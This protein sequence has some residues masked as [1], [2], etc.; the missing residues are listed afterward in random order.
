MTV[1][2]EFWKLAWHKVREVTAGYRSSLL[3]IKR[4]SWDF[5][6]AHLQPA[7]RLP[8]A[9]SGYCPLWTTRA[10]QPTVLHQQS[11]VWLPHKQDLVSMWV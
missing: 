8:G 11:Q 7:P 6:R 10:A 4:P 9:L 3:G 1:R 2:K 5:P